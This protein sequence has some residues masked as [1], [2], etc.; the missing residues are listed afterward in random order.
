MEVRAQLP[1]DTSD[2]LLW[3]RIEHAKKLWKLFDAI[4]M[5]KIYRIHSFSVSSISKMTYEDIQYIIDNMS[6][7]YS[8]K[9]ELSTCALLKDSLPSDKKIPNCHILIS[10]QEVIRKTLSCHILILQ[11]L[12]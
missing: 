4:G 5:N 9:I 1:A 6:V 7:D 12:E 2:A 10:V 11:S 3:K 8:I